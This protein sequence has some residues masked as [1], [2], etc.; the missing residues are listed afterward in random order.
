MGI[1][2]VDKTAIVVVLDVGALDIRL[3]R[4]ALIARGTPGLALQACRYD[5]VE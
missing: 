5:E 4:Q 2:L 1:I 3:E